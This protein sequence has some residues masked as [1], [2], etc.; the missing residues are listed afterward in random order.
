[1]GP[2]YGSPDAA[3]T[4]ATQAPAAQAQS[5]PEMGLKEY[6]TSVAASGPEAIKILSTQLRKTPITEESQLLS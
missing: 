4:A 6:I 3:R 2:M 5:A 1:M